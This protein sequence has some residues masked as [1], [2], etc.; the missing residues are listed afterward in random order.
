MSREEGPFL[1]AGSMDGTVAVLDAEDG[2]VLAK[3]KPHA[4]Y[5]VRVA[6][7]PSSAHVLS[8]SWDSTVVVQRWHP[9][10]THLGSR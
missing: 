10:E 7:A 4:K 1:L 3:S 5:C 2:T 6:W 8:A 9:G